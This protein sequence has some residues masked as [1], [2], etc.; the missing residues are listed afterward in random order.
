ML[1]DNI[2]WTRQARIRTE[3]RLLSNAFHSQIIL[4]W[5]SFYSVAISIYYFGAAQDAISSKSWLIYSVL[6][7]VVSVY[8]NGFSYKERAALI[9][10]NYERLKTLMT[11]AKQIESKNGDL[12][13]VAFSYE[14][15][16]KACEN[17]RQED[18][19]EALYEVY[20]S[21]EDKSK[22]IPK[23]TEY[24]LKKAKRNRR[25]R[26]I[27]LALFYLLPIAITLIL[28]VGSFEFNLGWFCLNEN[29]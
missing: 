18:Y 6:V 11:H 3:R 14:K 27:A 19:L 13:Q 9:K 1:S 8:I 5:Y 7:L 17:H 21:S 20:E 22:V 15:A 4:L 25:S 24:Q 29:N 12:T 28:N 23:P 10:E 2:W 26:N 16:L